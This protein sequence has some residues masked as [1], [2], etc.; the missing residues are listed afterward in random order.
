M[1]RLFFLLLALCCLLPTHADEGMWML[2]NLNKAVRR[3]MKE[4][5]LDMSL[6]QLYHPKKASL[7]D[8]IVS[9]GG[10]CSGVV[11]SEEGLLL[12][13]HH[14]G[15]S[16]VQQHSSPQH[17]Y[18]QDGFVA[19]TKAEE[20]PCPEL[21]ARFLIEQTDVTDRVLSPVTSAMDEATR[22]AVID[23][24]LYLIEEEI[25]QKDTTLVAVD[26]MITNEEFESVTLY[27]IDVKNH[28]ARTMIAETANKILIDIYKI[29][30]HEWFYS[31]PEP[32]DIEMTIT[33]WEFLEEKTEIGY[34]YSLRFEVA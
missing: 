1:K 22:S 12:T 33:N 18:L 9:F 16:S 28:F 15:F 30:T 5:G 2:S 34:R 32:V 29:N 11:V 17:D 26:S 24:M 19:Q 31:R 4:R 20:L 25:Y 10:F 21:Y 7:K 6:K 3:D 23:S 8:A 14:C 27:G 13:N